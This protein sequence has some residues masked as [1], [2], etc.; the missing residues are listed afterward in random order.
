MIYASANFQWNQCIPENV[1]EREPITAQQQTLSRK[2]AITR[3]KYTDIYQYRTWPVFYNGLPFCKLL[4]KSM[5][6]FKTNWTETHILTKTKKKA[7]TQPNFCGW[8]PVSNL[9][10]TL[11]WY[12]LLQTSKETNA[13]LQILLSRNEKC[14][15]DTDSD[16][17]HDLYVSAMLRRRY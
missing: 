16:E 1:I 8:L 15:D 2:R 9:I 6:L 12:K 10:C 5:H 13:S 17:Q 3:S 11:Q 14:N 7:G 4:M